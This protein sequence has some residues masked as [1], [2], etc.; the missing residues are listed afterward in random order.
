[1]RRTILSDVV[2]PHLR[3][4]LLVA[5]L[6]P[7]G[8]CPAFGEVLQSVADF[9]EMCSHDVFVVTTETTALEADELCDADGVVDDPTITGDATTCGTLL[10]AVNSAVKCTDYDYEPKTIVLVPGGTYELDELYD[11]RQSEARFGPKYRFLDDQALPAVHGELTVDGRG[12]SLGLWGAIHGNVFTVPSDGSLTL[13]DLLL[14]TH[15]WEVGWPVQ[16][17]GTFTA[18]SVQFIDNRPD[19]FLSQGWMWSA[20]DTLIDGGSRFDI[21]H[22]PAWYARAIYSPSGS[23]T[24]RDTR[25]EYTGVYPAFYTPSGSG[26]VIAA[27]HP[28]AAV[29]VERSEFVGLINTDCTISAEGGDIQIL[30]STFSGNEGRVTGGICYLPRRASDG[31][32]TVERSTFAGNSGAVYCEIDA[33]VGPYGPPVMTLADVTVAGNDAVD[34]YLEAAVRAGPGCTTSVSNSV[35]AN[36]TP[37]DCAFLSGSLVGST[38]VNM[39]SDGSCK[40][41][42]S[43]DPLLGALQD[44]GGPTETMLPLPGSRLIDGGT[45]CGALD[46]RGLARPAGAAC[47][48]GAAERQPGE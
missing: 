43:G 21:Q 8:G 44:N 16:S 39:D 22:W 1:M 32:L 18:H 6:A 47:D 15:K 14:L 38:D 42:L 31:S 25:F 10:A 46:Q 27:E 48:V 36:N 9:D 5:V 20:G 12:A 17:D 41:Q 24:I 11:V 28:V 2:R 26:S 35:F 4:A 7:A 23:L 30:D 29:T 33:L 40:F 19:D 3:S 45:S 37:A 34:E 13:Q